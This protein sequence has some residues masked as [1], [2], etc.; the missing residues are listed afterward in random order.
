[1]V[2]G[3][4]VFEEGVVVKGGVMV[5]GGVVVKGAAKVEATL[6]AAAAVTMM[7]KAAQELMPS[8]PFHPTPGVQ[9]MCCFLPHTNH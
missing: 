5:E 6:V 1:M 4:G 9:S 7:G 2:E 3:E 8:L